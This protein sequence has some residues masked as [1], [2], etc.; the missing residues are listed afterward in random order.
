MA[1]EAVAAKAT[2]KDNQK[3]LVLDEQSS[4]RSLRQEKLG[5]EQKP[6]AKNSF[7]DRVYDYLN[8][9]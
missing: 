2:R 8:K 3:S 6:E 4:I 1:S 5:S 9:N 7:R